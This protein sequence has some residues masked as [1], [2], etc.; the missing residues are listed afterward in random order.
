MPVPLRVSWLN[1]KK[2]ADTSLQGVSINSSHVNT[3][4]DFASLRQH[5]TV[6]QAPIRI[7]SFSWELMLTPRRGQSRWQPAHFGDEELE[8]SGLTVLWG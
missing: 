6:C 1:L 2:K 8:A 4:A 5:F 3:R 7:L